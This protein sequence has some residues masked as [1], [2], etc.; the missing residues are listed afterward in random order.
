MVKV[1]SI[2]KGNF[3]ETIQLKLIEFNVDEFREI[4]LKFQEK[5]D[6]LYFFRFYR[7]EQSYNSIYVLH[8]SL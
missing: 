7:P 2:G 1:A 8:R 3:R 4:E 6:F 5:E